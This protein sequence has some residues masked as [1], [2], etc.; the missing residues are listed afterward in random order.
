MHDAKEIEVLIH[1]LNFPC[2]Y[3]FVFSYINIYIEQNGFYL[4]S[5]V[6]QIDIAAGKFGR[7]PKRITLLFSNIHLELQVNGV[8]TSHSIPGNAIATHFNGS[9]LNCFEHAIKTPWILQNSKNQHTRMVINHKIAV[10]ILGGPST[11]LY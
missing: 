7:C 6:L 9:Y 10:A 11:K 5:R 2:L 3:L 1:M 8:M 4:P